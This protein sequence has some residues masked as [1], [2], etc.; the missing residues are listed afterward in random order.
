M[1]S[2]EQLG[3]VIAAAWLDPEFLARLKA[4][5]EGV[6]AEYGVE[7]P[8]GKKVVICEDTADTIHIVIPRRPDDLTDDEIEDG[9]V[10]IDAT[11]VE[12]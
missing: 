12:H 7:L 10:H 4:D 8:A 11:K 2:R 3:K 9:D 1:G 6:L 5:P